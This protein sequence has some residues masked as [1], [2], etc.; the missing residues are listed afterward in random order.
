MEALT[1]LP[2]GSTQLSA[3]D[4]A[5]ILLQTPEAVTYKFRKGHIRAIRTG[6]G[7]KAPWITCDVWLND[8]LKRWNKEPQQV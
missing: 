8:A 4:V 3:S 2:H 6:P 5:E 1:V 7:R